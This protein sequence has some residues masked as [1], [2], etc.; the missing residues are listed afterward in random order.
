MGIGQAT[1]ASVDAFFNNINI[2]MIANRQMKVN[3][4]I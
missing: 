3:D 2:G 1:E 4:N